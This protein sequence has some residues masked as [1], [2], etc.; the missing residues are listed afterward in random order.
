MSKT[1]T[2]PISLLTASQVAKRL[3]VSKSHAYNLMNTGEIPTVCIGGA[4]RVRPEDLEWFISTNLKVDKVD[5]F[6]ESYR[7]V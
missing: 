3:S 4:R 2:S 7:E 5:V 6:F 1:Q